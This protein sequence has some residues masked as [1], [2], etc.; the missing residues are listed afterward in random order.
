MTVNEDRK[1]H[2]PYFFRED[3]K[4]K[5]KAITE[6]IKKGMPIKNAFIHQGVNE[7]TFIKWQSF[8][9]EDWEDGFEDTPFMNFMR[10]VAIAYEDAHSDLLG[11][12]FQLADD[13]DSKMVMFLL[14]SLYGHNPNSKKEVEL[15]T[16]EDTTFNINIVE[17][18]KKDG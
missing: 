3:Y 6:D 15:S 1:P 18:K 10:N 8:L 5:L 16:T 9:R 13:G 11:K 17:P 2:Y 12:A 7:N 4:N 14:K